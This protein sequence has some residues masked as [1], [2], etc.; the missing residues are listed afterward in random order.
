MYTKGLGLVFDGPGSPAYLRRGPMALLVLH[1]A[2]VFISILMR[3]IK[4]K[5]KSTRSG[6]RGISG[7]PRVHRRV[8]CSFG[9]GAPPHLRINMQLAPLCTLWFVS[10]SGG[11][12][13]DFS[14]NSPRAGQE[15]YYVTLSRR[16]ETSLGG[17]MAGGRR[18]PPSI[19][20][21]WLGELRRAHAIINIITNSDFDQERRARCRS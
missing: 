7:F 16:L 8:S 4:K 18:L 19:E 15:D 6:A 2:L 11:Q 20:K 14:R 13:P 12:S 3:I 1:C 10:C 5:K 21:L 17:F 9:H